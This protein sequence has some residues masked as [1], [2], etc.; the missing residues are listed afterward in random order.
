MRQRYGASFL[1]WNG[2][3]PPMEHLGWRAVAEAPARGGVQATGKL[4]QVVRRQP[5]RRHI[6][7]QVAPQPTIGVF[8]C[9][10]LPGAAW[11]AEVARRAKAPVPGR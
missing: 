10:L 5:L 2:I 9:P 8:N 11:V 4:V 7:G 1:G 6:G 3:E